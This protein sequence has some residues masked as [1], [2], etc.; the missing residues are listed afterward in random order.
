[1]FLGTGSDKTLSA[2]AQPSSLATVGDRDQEMTPRALSSFITFKNFAGTLSAHLDGV[3]E[4]TQIEIWFQD[5]AR[6][7]RPKERPGSVTG[8]AWNAPSP[9]RAVSDESGHAFQ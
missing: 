8:Q 4:A 2:L 5:E 3:P 9:A 1:M 6:I 7:H